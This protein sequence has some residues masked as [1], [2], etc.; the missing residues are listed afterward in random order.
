M[1]GA[2][3]FVRTSFLP[4]WPH[5]IFIPLGPAEYWVYSNPPPLAICST[6]CVARM[7]LYAYTCC[8]SHGEKGRGPF[9]VQKRTFTCTPYLV[10]HMR[11]QECR[12]ICHVLSCYYLPVFTTKFLFKTCTIIVPI[13]SQY[14]LSC[15]PKVPWG[16]R[17]ICGRIVPSLFFKVPL[18]VLFVTCTPTMI[19][20]TSACTTST[21]YTL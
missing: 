3:I 1:L 2:Y 18:R 17:H 14:I 20:F 4:V 10:A 15:L 7:Y 6:V 5:E 11:P 16:I 13:D 12:A 19:Q 9:K 8:I 21:V